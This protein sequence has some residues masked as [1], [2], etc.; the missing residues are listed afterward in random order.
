MSEKKNNN[1]NA[2]NDAIIWDI[3]NVIADLDYGTVT[4]KVHNG[5]IAQIE[6]TTKRRFDDCGLVEKGGG[7]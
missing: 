6:T 7:I 5:R 1:E 4:I 3:R 2:T